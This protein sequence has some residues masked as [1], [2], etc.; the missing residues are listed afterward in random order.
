[1]SLTQVWGALLM[2]S[3]IPLLG[4]LPLI[5]WITYGLSGKRLRQLGQGNVS[6]SAAFIYGGKPIGILCVVSEALKGI[7]A[8][9]LARYFFPAD[10]VWEILSLIALVMGRYWATRGAGTTNVFW[11]ILTH[12]TWGALLVLLIGGGSFTIFRDRKLGRLIILGLLV[13]ILSARHPQGAYFLAILCLAGI[14]A[15]IWQTIP[16]DLDTPEANVKMETK[17]SFRFFRGDKALKSLN[18]PLD[19]QKVGTKA[20]TLAYLKSLGYAVPPGWLFFAGDDPQPLIETTNPSSQTP[21]AVRSSAIGEDGEFASAAGQYLS[22]LNVTTPDEL[23]T[24]IYDCLAAYDRP[25]AIQYRRDRQQAESVMV[26]L[27]QKQIRG[28]FSGV[29]FSR[30]PVNPLSGEIRIETL[31]GEASRVVSGQVT[32]E[33]YGVMIAESGD[34]TVTS[35]RP[36]GDVPRSLIE[37]VARLA[38][39]LEDLFH[40]IPQDIEWTYDGDQ[41]WLLQARAIATLQPIWTRK[42]AAEVI[43]GVIRPLP[44]SINR[45]LTCGVWGEIFGLVLGKKAQDLDFNQTATLHFQQAYFNATLLGQIFRRMGLPPESLEF[46]TRGAKFSKPPLLAMLGNSKGL[47]KL[48]GREWQLI[49][50]FGQDNRALFKPVLSQ[51]TTQSPDRLSETEILARINLILTTLQRATYYSILAPL[52]FALRQGI[53]KIAPESLDYRHSPE[54]AALQAL[55]AIAIPIRA[56]LRSK[57]ESLEAFKTA[58]NRHPQSAD[59]L[60]E[61]EQWR[62][63]Y[64]YLSETATDISIPRWQEDP[65]LGWHSLWQASLKT[66]SDAQGRSQS[67]SSGSFL[68]WQQRQVQQRLNLKGQVTEIYSQ[69][70]AH[71]RW[72]FLALGKRWT[73]TNL[74][75][76][77]DDIFFLEFEEIEQYIQQPKPKVMAQKISQ[78]RSQFERNQA[79]NSIPYIV[80]GNPTPDQLFDQVLD[81][82][83]QIS[84]PAIG[85]LQGIGASPGIVEGRI[86]VLTSL[87]WLTD[88]DKTTILVVPYTDSGWTTLISRAGGIIAEVGGSLSHGAIVAREYGIPAVMDIPYATQRFREGQR[89]RMDGRRGIVEILDV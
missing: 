73:T 36:G 43:P 69:L 49:R 67:K 38:R 63:R 76:I 44:W 64:G 4:S 39:E 70:L 19:P 71:L 28:A 68:S 84:Q 34:V 56:Y 5:D 2:V 61:F 58:I 89:V 20:A 60:R 32:P 23:Q 33:R 29:A 7:I 13:F 85:Q 30:D 59:I 6:I 35:D 54:I 10:A 86:R 83:V 40:G 62:D 72:S 22:I 1:M 75:S 37:S 16:D 12:D 9:L 48:I 80:Y 41:L 57:P 50:D 74:L 52:S 3:L 81:H 65:D 51:L 87:Q 78:R 24:A 82:S 88:I 21:L 42:I 53:L 17:N 26:V 25:S 8:V 45:P 46:L 66:Q 11:G 14:E 47:A 18:D 79:L 55:D 77:P 31:P 15:W 27:V